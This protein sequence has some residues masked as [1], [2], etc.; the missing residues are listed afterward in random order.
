ME[1]GTALAFSIV[2]N[3]NP[4]L[5][6]ASEHKDWRIRRAAAAALPGAGLAD[7]KGLAAIRALFSDSSS[8]VKQ[9]LAAACGAAKAE[10]VMLPLIGL[11]ILFSLAIIGDMASVAL[12]DQLGVDAMPVTVLEDFKR[13]IAWRED[14]T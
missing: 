1:D 6:A 11:F 9:T 2:E 4:T 12:A 5:V 13:A 3:T 14:E 10:A 8:T 7:P